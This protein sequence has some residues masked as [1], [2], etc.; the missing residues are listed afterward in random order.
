LSGRYAPGRH[1]AVCHVERSE[2]QSRHLASNIARRPFAARFLRAA[3]GLGRNDKTRPP[4]LQNSQT[5]AVLFL[6][7]LFLCASL[8]TALEHWGRL[9]CHITA[10]HPPSVFPPSHHPSSEKPGSLPKPSLRTPAPSVWNPVA[11]QD[12]TEQP[13]IPRP[14]ANSCRPRRGRPSSQT[15][16]R[17]IALGV[18]TP[19]LPWATTVSCPLRYGHPKPPCHYPVGNLFLSIAADPGLSLTT[20]RSLCRL[21]VLLRAEGDPKGERTRL[22]TQAA[23]G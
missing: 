20:A 8:P 16:Y 5:E 11:S 1:I 9:T 17:Y 23:Y 4:R 7:P 19:Y 22:G 18:P 10:P 14:A 3:F 21:P 12:A 2:A 13:A 15:R 6:S